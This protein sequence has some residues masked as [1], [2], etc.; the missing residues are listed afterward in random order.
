MG[1]SE[2]I[3]APTAAGVSTTRRFLLVVGAVIGAV[4][5]AAMLALFG[6]R[7]ARAGTLPGVQVADLEVGDLSEDELRT[8]LTVYGRERGEEPVTATREA[9]Q[10]DP[11]AAATFAATAAEVG[12]VFDAEAT[13]DVVLARGRQANPLTALGDQL[14]AFGT[15]ITID[16]VED[17][18]AV[19]LDAW[20][21]RVAQELALP[22]QEG[23]VRFAGVTVERVDP[24]PGLEVNTGALR[25]D[26]QRAALSPGPDSLTIATQPVDA[27]ATAEEVDA[28]VAQAQQ[29]LSAPVS[30]TRG[31]DTV[32]LAPEQLATILRVEPAEG[33]QGLELRADPAALGV[34][35]GDPSPVDVPAVDASLQLSGGVINID[36]G[37]PGFRVD[38]E[39]AAVQVR[40]LAIGEAPRTAEVAGEEVQPDRT[41]DEVRALGISQQVSTYTTQHPCCANRVQNIHRIADLIRG[42][43]IEPGETFSVNDFVGERTSANGFLADGAIQQGEFV[44]EVGGGVSQFATTMFNAAYEGGYDI[45]EHKPHSQYISRYPE[46]REA[47]LNFP[48]VDLKVNNNS[49]HGIYIDTSYTD[50]SITVSF[51]STPWVSVSSATS[52]RS[53]F[54]PPET[55][56]RSN[57]ELAPGQEVVVQEGQGQ[58][59]NVTVTRTLSFPDGRTESEDYHTTYVARPRIVERG[60]A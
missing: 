28:A 22:P 60:T 24:T 4:L 12:Y 11:R 40:D 10:G 32:T 58:G 42:V 25:A 14:R 52:A 6:L 8:A 21:S 57:S 43:I 5:L 7:A 44:Q 36:E 27:A 19:T 37:E 41:V 30:L 20:V 46:G 13:A 18:Q 50:T 53:N 49:P 45:V 55:I 38:L 15:E 33:G 48:N 34:A 26:A 56:V 16:P 2:S 1:T 47:T 51:W 3:E 29:A 35:I 23:T 17:V 39:A 9:P 31:Q 59:F 54:T